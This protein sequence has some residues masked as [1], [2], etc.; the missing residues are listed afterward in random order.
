MYRSVYMQPIVLLFT[1][2]LP[3][4][5]CNEQSLVNDS[6]VVR[7]SEDDQCHYD[8]YSAQGNKSVLVEKKACTQF[9]Y[10]NE[11]SYAYEVI[12]VTYK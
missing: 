5:T 8:L 2:Y 3:E 11:L 6:M 4:Y 12:H 9:K 10:S 1:G 7:L